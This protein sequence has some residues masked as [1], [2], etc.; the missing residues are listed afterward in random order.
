V[1]TD[2]ADST[3]NGTLRVHGN[4]LGSIVCASEVDGE[5][6][7]TQ[8]AYGLQI[9][10]P[11]QFGTCDGD[12]Y[13]AG[14]L[15]IQGNTGDVLGIDVSDNIVRGT[16]QGD[17]NTPAP[18]GAGNRFRGE[19]TGQFSDLPPASDPAAERRAAPAVDAAT[20]DIAVPERLD[21]VELDARRA[22]ASQASVEAGAAF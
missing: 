11:G 10:G 13:W 15:T 4:E 6:T 22:A 1:L 19:A 7:F 9:G 18:T 2:L 5:A 20:V 14:S 12:N 17:G 8:N 21:T 3:I 16:I